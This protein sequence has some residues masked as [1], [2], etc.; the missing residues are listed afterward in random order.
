LEITVEEN[1]II[2][3]DDYMYFQYL[4]KKKQD[5]EAWKALH[6]EDLSRYK[7]LK[8]KYSLA[9]EEKGSQV[10]LEEEE[11]PILGKRLNAIGNNLASTP[12]FEEPK[13]KLKIVKKDP[14]EAKKVITEIK[15]PPVDVAK[16]SSKIAKSSLVNYD[17]DSEASTT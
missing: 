10:L 9:P 5:E 2:Y 11:G 3:N 14:V 6:Q 12:G 4:G 13:I 15:E 17:S 1:D 16:P 8:A 7:K